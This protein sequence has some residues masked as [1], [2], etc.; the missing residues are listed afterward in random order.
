MTLRHL[1]VSTASSGDVSLLALCG[2]NTTSEKDILPA[3]LAACTR[4]PA[5]MRE[6]CRSTPLSSR[7]VSV[8]AKQ[9]LAELDEPEVTDAVAGA[10]LPGV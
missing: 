1:D 10:E 8:P 7:T 9:S 6:I 2:T 3:A 4:S 5:V